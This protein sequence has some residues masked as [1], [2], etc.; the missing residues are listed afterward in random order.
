MANQRRATVHC[1]RFG[2]HRS[3]RSFEGLDAVSVL[4]QAAA[5]QAEAVRWID[6]GLILGSLAPFLG[7]F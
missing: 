2:I 4:C 1:W 7:R 6:F 5:N 3:C